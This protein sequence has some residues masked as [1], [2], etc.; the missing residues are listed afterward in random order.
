MLNSMDRQQFQEVIAKGETIVFG[1]WEF[2]SDGQSTYF[3]RLLTRARD[4]LDAQAF[5]IDLIS[6][7]LAGM[8]ISEDVMQQHP[9]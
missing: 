3:G 5:R 6:N 4:T 2:T 1:S 8:W 9:E 7:K